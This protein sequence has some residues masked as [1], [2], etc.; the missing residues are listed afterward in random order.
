MEIFMFF[1]LSVVMALLFFQLE[2]FASAKTELESSLEERFGA[3]ISQISDSLKTHKKDFTSHPQKLV[4]FVDD[5]ILPIWSSEHL[6]LRLFSKPIWQPLSQ[7]EKLGLRNA[8]YNTMQR[9]A[10]EGFKYYDGQQLRLSKVRLNPKQTRG[11]V[12]V[13]L[14]QSNLP[15]F[16]VVF[17]I[18]LFDNDWKFYD[19]MFQG[20]SY[21][22]LKK[23]H[24]RELVRGIGVEGVVESIREKNKS[25]L[26]SKLTEEAN[27][28]A[29]EHIKNVKKNKALSKKGFDCFESLGLVVKNDWY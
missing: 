20:V 11:Y 25:F 10:Q 16:E 9:Y 18:G 6:L 15:A 29:S 12:T 17:K 2:Q 3:V 24:F 8:F 23:S 4:D 19:V 5:S 14:L 1:K 28:L 26:P 7:Q 13:E 27:K 22:S 21:I